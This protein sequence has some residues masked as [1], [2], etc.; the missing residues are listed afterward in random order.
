DSK[1]EVRSRDVLFSR[2]NTYD[3]VAACAYVFSTIPKLLMSDLI[4]RLIIKNEDQLNPIFLWKLLV[5]NSQRKL[6]QKMA[7]GAAGSMPNISKTNLKTS[8]V[9]VPPISIQ[10]NYA[11]IVEKVES[12]KSR[13]QQSLTE[14]ENLYGSVSQKAFK[15]ELDLSRIPLLEEDVPKKE[16]NKT[17]KL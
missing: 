16:R 10:S 3:L 7:G 11:S 5:C 4:F 15:G 14:L 6:I 9:I 2:K 13:Y 12:I 1:Y 17:D 8:N